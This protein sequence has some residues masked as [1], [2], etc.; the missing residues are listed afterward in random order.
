MALQLNIVGTWKT[1]TSGVVTVAGV[2]RPLIEGWEKVAG[3]WRQFWSGIIL[4]AAPTSLSKNAT[5]IPQNVTTSTCTVTVAG[6]SGSGF[7]SYAWTSGTEI[8][9]N[10]PSS[11]T[12]TFSRYV[13]GSGA[14]QETMICKV[15]D[16][17]TGAVGTIGVPV[18]IGF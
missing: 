2:N 9:A 8:T 6:G 16:T 18:Q 10:N 15:T 12:T 3:T 17:V 14:L 1:T 5:S 11:A 13:E 4:S 7:Y